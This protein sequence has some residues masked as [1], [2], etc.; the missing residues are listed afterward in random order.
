METNLNIE[1][2]N[3]EKEIIFEDEQ[4]TGSEQ[5]L[6]FLFP[7]IGMILY[8]SYIHRGD[9]YVDM[10]RKAGNIS[11]VGLIAGAVI[12]IYIQYLHTHQG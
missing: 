10:A 6:C 8:L 7:I 4:L 1:N 2:E 9:C 11:W 5:T 3:D 12:L